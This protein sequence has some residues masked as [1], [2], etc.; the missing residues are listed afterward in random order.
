M[1]YFFRK[2]LSLLLLGT[3][4]VCSGC[5]Q[6]VTSNS[7]SSSQTVYTE[8]DVEYLTFDEAILR[9]DTAIIGQYVETI[10]Q[11]SYSE[12][13]FQVEEV[14]YGSVDGDEIYVYADVAECYVS[15]IDYRYETGGELYTPGHQYV[16][17][18][19]KS[20]SVMYD[21]DRY[22][23]IG[24][25][26]LDQDAEQYTMYSQELDFSG[27]EPAEYIRSVHSQAETASAEDSSASAATYENAVEE[28]VQR[29]DYVGE[30]TIESLEIEGEVH[31]G[32]TYQCSVNKL[33]SGENLTTDEDGSVLI[34]LEKGSVEVGK[35]YVIGFSPV[36]EPSILYTQETS[37][38][39]YDSDDTETIDMIEAYAS[40]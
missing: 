7:E 29:A 22:M 15:E 17:V 11:E 31:N 20:T 28:M 35:S 21:H 23:T 37:E 18:M 8:K 12:Y 38:S 13:K 24:D 40:E 3:L 1:K 36:D 4:A 9:S 34:V 19:E 10:D 33:Y 14:L 30:V 2:S 39:I 16:L 5:A 25:L 27:E 26:L 32:N 6:P